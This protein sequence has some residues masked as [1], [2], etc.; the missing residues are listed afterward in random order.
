MDR[1]VFFVSKGKR[2]F[3]NH[4]PFRSAA[5]DLYLLCVK[6]VSTCHTLERIFFLACLIF[7]QIISSSML[8]ASHTICLRN[9]PSRLVLVQRAVVFSAFFLRFSSLVFLESLYECLCGCASQ[10]SSLS[11]KRLSQ[12]VGGRDNFT[13][14]DHF[15]GCRKPL[16]HWSLESRCCSP[17][18]TLLMVGRRNFFHYGLRLLRLVVGGRVVACKWDGE[19]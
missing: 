5:T 9:F 17:S 16:L 10:E 12:R 7:T 15:C 2:S 3:H 11:W 19:W 14:L 4:V 1:N 6:T 18:T 13:L 8:V